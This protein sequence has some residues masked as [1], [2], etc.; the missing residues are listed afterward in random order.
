MIRA[1]IPVLVTAVGFPAKVRSRPVAR[2]VNYEAVAV[3]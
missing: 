2:M 3:K 1:V